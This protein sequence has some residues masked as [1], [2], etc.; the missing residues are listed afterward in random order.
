MGQKAR[1]AGQWN[2]GKAGG[3]RMKT[4]DPIQ[5]L[6][7]G[8]ALGEMEETEHGDWVRLEDAN[9]LLAALI[10]AAET[11]EFYKLPASNADSAKKCRDAI[12]KLE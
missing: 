3:E 10:E 6:Y 7:Q 11:F 9:M 12:A 5:R 8:T 2:L 1:S 4:Y